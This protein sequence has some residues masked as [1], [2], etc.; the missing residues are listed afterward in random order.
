MPLKGRKGE[1]RSTEGKTAEEIC[2]ESRRLSRWPP[3]LM[4]AIAC[5]IQEKIL[6][7]TV[8]LRALSWNEHIAAGHTPFRKDCKVCQQAS[9]KDWPHRRS[10]LPAKVGVL[11]LD[12]S[13]PYHRAPDVYAGK[14]AKYLLVACF[15][16]FAP[17][18]EGDEVQDPDPDE[19]E[20]EDGPEL[21]DEEARREEERRK[22]EEAEGVVR[23]GRPRNPEIPLDLPPVPRIVH[24]PE[25]EEPAVP[26]R[27]DVKIGVTRMCVPLSSRG[28]Q[29]V[30]RAIIDMHLR[31]KAD[32][33]TVNQ[34]HTDQGGEFMTDALERWCQ[35]RNIL[36]T[37]TPGD[38]PQTNGRA[39]VSVQC[40][41]AAIKRILTGAGVG[42]EKWPLAARFLNEKMHLRQIGKKDN[43]PPFLSKVLIRKRYWRVQELGPTQEEATYI[44]P[45]WVHHGHWI[46]RQ[47][48]EITLVRMV[49]KGLTEPIT[50]EHWIGIEDSLNPIEERRRI[51]GKVAV[52][53]LHVKEGDQKGSEDPD[54]LGEDGGRTCQSDRCYWNPLDPR[55][56]G[57]Y[58]DRRD[59]EDEEEDQEI[60]KD[61]EDLMKRTR[62]VIEEEMFRA[63][64]DPDEAVPATMDSIA[65]MK[66]MVVKPE[67]PDEVLQ[68]K[69][70]AMHEVRKDLSKWKESMEKELRAM[71]E[72][73]KAL[74]AI[75]AEEVKR[76]VREEKAEVIPSKL[77]CTL[78]P[79][80]ENPQG[81]CKTR[82]VACGNF[83]ENEGGPAELFAGGASAVALRG[84]VAYSSQRGW[85][86][87]VVDIKAAFL[88]APMNQEV[89]GEG[90]NGKQPKRPIIKPPPILIY[91]GLAK[92]DEYW[93]A[94]KAVYGYRRSPRLWSTHREIQVRGEECFL[95][96]M[97]TEGD[98]WKVMK[99]SLEGQVEPPN[100]CLGLVLVYVDDLL[101]LGTPDVRDAV[102]QALQAK[103]ETS[104]PEDVGQEKGVR[105]LG[106]ELWCVPG[107]EWKITQENYTIDLLKRNL[108]SDMS[109]WPQKK[110]PLWK[111]P[112][113]IPQETK[114]ISQVRE[115]Q[116][117]V[118]E[119]VW[120]S[121]KSRPDLM[122][123]ISKM[124]SMITRNPEAVPQMAQ[125]VWAYLA[126][127]YDQG[128]RYQAP[129]DTQ[130]LCIHTDSSF[131]ETCH[132]C[133][134]LQWGGGLL[135][136]K[137]SKQSVLSVSTA[138]SELIEL[139]D[140]A[141]SGEAVKVVLEELTSDRVHS[142][143]F[144]DNAAAVSITTA[145]SGSW[146][147]R[148]LRKR[149]S[150]LRARIAVGEWAV[151]HLPGNTMPADLGTK[152]AKALKAI[153]LVAKMSQLAVVIWVPW[154]P[155]FWWISV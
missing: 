24:L 102:I 105:F 131:G 71:F 65:R 58:L 113:F 55:G 132:G 108:G 120:L 152:V 60:G 5:Q 23:R 119:L 64:D 154:V 90:G 15:T 143:S 78:K 4:R 69:I 12:M 48:G 155:F 122:Y 61:P 3:L 101:I 128:L 50:D 25:P 106:T 2:A 10:P 124:G 115:A 116:R 94:E 46:Q 153:I 13:G 47:N 147:T 81:R 49:M 129:S 1:V 42:T 63:I 44:A 33:Y 73:K 14:T 45:S 85:G 77:V 112:D 66:E 100:E 125:D 87:T 80:P 16:W 72:E 27:E 133:I 32:G 40:C 76:L 149:A 140:G 126:D 62:K 117:I 67:S 95:Q 41:K 57:F 8:Q 121:T 114:E 130:E 97:M 146:R 83:A 68:T 79:S 53:G 39:E 99:S 26:V 135:L 145:D 6:K 9:A 138:E 17:D 118:G 59:H 107:G 18:P 54:L 134:L 28:N 75:P 20:P 36:K 142:M 35:S 21:E 29:E 51:R 70:V 22:E 7:S 30:L 88:N 110:V 11:S 127:T 34:L 89:I 111:E 56:D 123:V 148:H 84:A 137:S 43:S 150:V 92:E 91:A 136:W 93:E 19:E 52:Q 74:R 86:G 151:K 141:C 37:T 98:L 104:E 38:S 109:L 144:T 31:L 139:V 103:W 96:Q 82:L